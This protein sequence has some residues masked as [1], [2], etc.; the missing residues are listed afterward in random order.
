MAATLSSSLSDIDDGGHGGDRPA[1]GLHRRH[2]ECAA[3]QHRQPDLHRHRDQHAAARYRS[4]TSPIRPALPLQ[5]GANANPTAGRRQFL[6]P[7]WPRWCRSSTRRSA[8]R[9]LQ[10]SNPPARRCNLLGS[11]RQRRSTRPRPRRR[12]TSLTSG[13]PQLPLFTDGNALYTGAITGSGSQMTGLAGR[14]TVNP[15]LVNNP[16]ELSIYTHFAGRRRPATPR[17]RITCSRS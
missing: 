12:S 7:A 11:G 5:N 10:F 4:S 1:G 17:A 16:S 3:G 15:A 8:T 9:G 13:N 2:V 14:I 6:R